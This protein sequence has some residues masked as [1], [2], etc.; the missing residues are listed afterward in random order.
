MELE[1]R[2][3]KWRQ[4]CKLLGQAGGQRCLR[5]IKRAGLPER[6]DDKPL[7]YGHSLYSYRE[8]AMELEL[9]WIKRRYNCKLLSPKDCCWLR[10]GRLYSDQCRGSGNEYNICNIICKWSQW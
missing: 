10:Y 7:Q 3:I 4:H 2:W 1:L 8:R 9:R 6:A 5:L